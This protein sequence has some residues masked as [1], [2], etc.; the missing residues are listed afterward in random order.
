[1]PELP[2]VETVRRYL[3]PRLSGRRIVRA[4]VFRRD[5][6]LPIDAALARRLRGREIREVAR[7]AKYLL[8]NTDGGTLIFH[9]GMSGTLRLFT[10][11]GAKNPRLRHDHLEVEIS[12]GAL[13]RY[14]DP[15]RFGLVLWR[16]DGGEMPEK[17]FGPEPLSRAFNG[18]YLYRA[19]RG[20]KIA[21]KA[22]LLNPRIAAGVGN[23]YAGE[24]LHRA[25]L[26]PAKTA[27]GL[28]L[29][30]CAKLTAAIKAVLRAA[31]KSGGSSA[32][33]FVGGGG[34]PGYFQTRWRV[35]GR[36]GLPCKNCGALIR[37]IVQAQR[38]TFYCP[39]CQ[40]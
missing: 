31:I 27:G 12:G 11:D 39:R 1:M 4:A 40:R 16:A 23:I 6:R 30:E 24:S 8:I 13:L 37:R 25:G 35:Y 29:A 38:A 20:R 21:I 5:L 19:I 7:R 28:S 2:E 36:A 26:S 9:F 22:A 10:G 15:R 3:S 18:G 34:E 17:Q 14:H 32:R 33:D